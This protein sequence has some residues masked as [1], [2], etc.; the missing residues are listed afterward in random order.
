M[1]GMINDPVKGIHY[2][3]DLTEN[4]VREIAREEIVKAR[5]RA[6]DTYQGGRLVHFFGDDDQEGNKRRVVPPKLN[7]NE[8][9]LDEFF[10]HICESLLEKGEV[11]QHSKKKI[12]ITE[13]EKAL[14]CIKKKRALNKPARTMSEH[15]EWLRPE[16]DFMKGHQL[17]LLHVADRLH[18]LFEHKENRIYILNAADH[19]ASQD[20]RIKE[21]EQEIVEWKEAHQQVFDDYQNLGDE[22]ASK[23][24]YPSEEAIEQAGWLIYPNYGI[25]SNEKA[26][27]IIRKIITELGIDKP[28]KVKLDDVVKAIELQSPAPHWQWNR[29][30]KIALD[31]AGVE[32]D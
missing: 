6:D 32:Y 28:K 22:L 12:P 4:R 24:A 23:P 20:A 11:G 21:L 26:Q 8:L 5:H 9:W 27:D 30:V 18:G 1:K 29:I 2:V 14:E 3:P 31:A 16:P 7:E 15:E 25:D 10:Q 19:I 17:R 13:I